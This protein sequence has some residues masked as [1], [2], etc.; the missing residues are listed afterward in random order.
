[1]KRL[2]TTQVLATLLGQYCN[3]ANKQ[4]A[5]ITLIGHS[6]DRTPDNTINFKIIYNNL[7]ARSQASNNNVTATSIILRSIIYYKYIWPL[8]CITSR[9]QHK[10]RLF[11]LLAVPLLSTLYNMYVCIAIYKSSQDS[12]WFPPLVARYQ[13]AQPS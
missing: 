11:V 8:L 7:L 4:Q 6:I 9:V 2:C 13:T 1:M 12:L 10:F 3:T 5:K